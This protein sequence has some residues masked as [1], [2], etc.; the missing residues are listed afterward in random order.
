MYANREWTLA[1]R[2]VHHYREKTWTTEIV[3]KEYHKLISEKTEDIIRGVLWH[4]G[5][6]GKVVRC[7]REQVEA[8]IAE[9][10]LKLYDIHSTGK[11][12]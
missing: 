10:M 2:L 5:P 1:G 7:S 8:D 11:K 12:D 6:D 9:T 3:M 4:F